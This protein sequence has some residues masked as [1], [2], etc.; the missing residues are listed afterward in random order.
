MKEVVLKVK[1][2][3]EI[4]LDAVVNM[5]YD[6][7]S[8][9]VSEMKVGELRY[10]A[11]YGCDRSTSKYKPHAGDISLLQSSMVKAGM[12]LKRRGFFVLDPECDAYA[13]E[14]DSPC[15]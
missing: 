10:G 8:G 5:P 1:R 7:A 2:G 12:A 13:E 15:A 6:V 14:R 11:V 3:N 9:L 4:V